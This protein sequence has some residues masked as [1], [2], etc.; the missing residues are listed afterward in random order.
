MPVTV[1][2]PGGALLFAST[3]RGGVM[4]RLGIAQIERLH[5]L[6]VRAGL[7]V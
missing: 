3:L 4:Q 6:A 7:G 5:K 2:A 1:G